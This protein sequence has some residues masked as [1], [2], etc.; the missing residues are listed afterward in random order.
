MKLI[1]FFFAF[2]PVLVFAQT[3]PGGVLNN[4]N[5]VFWIKA[6]VGVYNDAG[7]TLATNGQSIRQWNDYSGNTKNFGENAVGQQPAFTTNVMNG[8]PTARFDGNNDRLSNLTITSGS[9]ANIFAVARYSTLPSPNPGIFQGSPAGLLLSTGGADKVVGMWVSN[10]NRP[11]G[12]GIQTNNTAISIPTSVA[13]TANTNYIIENQYSG[14]AITQYVNLATSGS[15]AYNGTL[16]SWAEFAIGRQGTE[17]WAGD[18]AEVIAFNTSINLA[19][20]TIVSNYLSS[21]YNIA[22]A[23]A[24]DFYAGDTGAN[25]D[26]DFEVGGIGQS[27]AGNTNN[28]F[29]PSV[30]GGM[31]ITY[32]SGFQDGDYI[33]AGHNLKT[34]NDATNLDC[35]GMT[36]SQ[37]QR[38][39]RIWYVDATDVAPKIVSDVTFDMSDGGLAG[40]VPANAANY[41]LLN[42]AG[43]SGNWTESMIVPTI[44]GDQITFSGVSLSDGY[45]TIGTKNASASPLPIELLYLKGNVCNK[46][47]CLEWATASERNN[48]FYTVQQSDDAINFKNLIDVH[49]KSLNG[50][51]N[52]K[53][54]YSTIDE[55]PHA[56]INYY[57][58]KQT[59]LDGTYSYSKVVS[60]NALKENNI[61]FTVYPNPSPNNFFLDLSKF[62]NNQKLT[63]TLISP[64]GKCVY[65]SE[66]SASDDNHEQIEIIPTTN[67]AKGIYFCTIMSEGIKYSSKLLIN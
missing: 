62:E 3:G 67:L 58:L 53:L 15:A 23:A 56:N 22:I 42:R 31:G 44:S 12:R 5:N 33:F 34:G 40:I 38:W 48:D 8:F 55:N 1:L 20:R 6:D 7:V 49:S 63:I 16:K 46:E 17:T 66:L 19:Q 11:W 65:F 45:Y 10:A 57:R 35:G 43:T 28:S 30:S 21:K 60:V 27:S 51:S 59:D 52:K 13:T 24:S 14:T 26:Y 9:S 4:T 2:A 18:I 54:V 36:G 29:S 39:I 64:D 41:V 47:V 32:V 37:N 50:N 25:G 61:K